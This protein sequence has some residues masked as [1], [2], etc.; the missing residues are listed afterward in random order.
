MD[1][2]FMKQQAAFWLNSTLNQF[3]KEVIELARQRVE[4]YGDPAARHFS[5][6]LWNW[7]QVRDAF[8]AEDYTHAL[9]MAQGTQEA[10]GEIEDMKSRYPY[11]E[12]KEQASLAKP[13]A[14]AP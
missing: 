6:V 14:T 13:F 4:A 1:E 2:A 11:W 5:E 7:R 8:D 3:G 10:I 9:R 12:S